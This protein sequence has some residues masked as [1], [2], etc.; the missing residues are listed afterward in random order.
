MGA[1]KP[2]GLNRM[3]KIG[4]DHICM[5]ETNFSCTNNCII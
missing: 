1:G 2:K 4:Y 5:N 3:A